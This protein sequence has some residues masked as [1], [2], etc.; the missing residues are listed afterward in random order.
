MDFDNFS[1][2]Y[3]FKIYILT[4][5]CFVVQILRGFYEIKKSTSDLFYFLKKSGFSYP[6]PSKIQ[7]R[8]TKN[9]RSPIGNP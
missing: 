6:N 9:D 8:Q 3:T 7:H 4:Y 2:A 5:F 1:C